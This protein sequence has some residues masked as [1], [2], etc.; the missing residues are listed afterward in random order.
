MRITYVFLGAVL[1][2][3]QPAYADVASPPVLQPQKQQAQAAQ[4]SAQFLTRFSYKPIP[5]DDA[6][7]AKVL[8]RYIKSLDP[9]H[10]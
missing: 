9:D 8:D 1:A 5:L 6:L 10:M 3:V 7:S 4:L 2:I